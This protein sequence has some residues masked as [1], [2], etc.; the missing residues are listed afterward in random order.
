MSYKTSMREMKRRSMQ[1]AAYTQP[2]DA[3]PGELPDPLVEDEFD[4]AV[5]VDGGQGEYVALRGW[6]DDPDEASDC[7][8]APPPG[9]CGL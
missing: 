8:D 2:D 6:R 7:P 9:W 1:R 3:R 4:H 5:H